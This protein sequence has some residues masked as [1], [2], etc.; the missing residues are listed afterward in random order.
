MRLSDIDANRVDLPFALGVLSK[1]VGL[2][3]LI[4]TNCCADS[5]QQKTP[6]PNQ[7]HDFHHSV[8]CTP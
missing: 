4:L 1:D 7:L 5:R 3:G 2:D 6:S 8:L